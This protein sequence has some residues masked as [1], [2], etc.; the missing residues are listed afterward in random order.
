M[1]EFQR[2]TYL[3]HVGDF[4]GDGKRM[5]KDVESPSIWRVPDVPHAFGDHYLV[6]AGQ[7]GGY[8]ASFSNTANYAEI[9]AVELVQKECNDNFCIPNCTNEFGCGGPAR[10]WW[11]GLNCVVVT[12][13]MICAVQKPMPENIK[14]SLDIRTGINASGWFHGRMTEPDIQI[15]P[16]GNQQVFS[17][18]AAPV[19]VPALFFGPKKYS[20]LPANLQKWW[21]NCLAKGT[22]PSSS[23]IPSKD[24]KDGNSG[25]SI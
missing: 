7:D 16:F 8:G 5:I 12:D 4:V 25:S 19:R 18:T 3:D 22:C 21:N 13:D 9:Y 17:I 24:W 23:R 6:V 2:Y 15:T 14:F 10:D 20:E 1:G 11:G